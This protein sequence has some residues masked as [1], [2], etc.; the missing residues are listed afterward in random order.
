MDNTMV[1]T[2]IDNRTFVAAQVTS[3][4]CVE[5]TK[6]IN[7]MGYSYKV[8]AVRARINRLIK[9]GYAD[10]L[11]PYSDLKGKRG[12]KTLKQTMA[13]IPVYKPTAD[14]TV[15]NGTASVTPIK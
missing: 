8:S 2:Q 7:S 5:L 15:G 1:S 9:C 3:A 6:K 14:K 13:S 11:R 10:R 4:D 12:K